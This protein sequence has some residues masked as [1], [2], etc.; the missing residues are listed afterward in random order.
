MPLF[1]FPRLL[2]FASLSR[3]HLLP[4]DSHMS[5]ISPNYI[6]S[7]L[8]HCFQALKKFQPSS[9]SVVPQSQSQLH[10]STDDNN[11]DLSAKFTP[12][13]LEKHMEVEDPF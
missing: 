2:Q 13:P 12:H 6:D 10:K 1:P 8:D 11:S 5:P 7:D 3:S 4:L 9:S